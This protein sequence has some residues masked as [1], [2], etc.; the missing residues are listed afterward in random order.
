MTYELHPLCTLFP[1]LQ[2]LDFEALCQDILANGLRE[3]IVLHEGMILDGGN[4]YRACMHVGV[5]PEFREFGGGNIVDY[6]LSTN[7]YRRHLTPGQQAAIVSSAQNWAN[8]QPAHRPDKAGNVA[9]LSTVASRSA[10]SGASERTQ[11]MADKVAKADPGLAKKVA[12]GEVSLPK[13][14]KQVEAKNPPKPRKTTVATETASPVT[15]EQLAPGPVETKPA[16]DDALGD[17]DPYDEIKRMQAELDAAHALVKAAEADDL[18]AE[19]MKWRRAY[20]HAQREQSIAMD[21]YHNEAK[22]H[23]FKHRQLM[24]CGKAVGEEDPDKVAAAVEAFV[25][26]HKVAA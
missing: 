9:G 13:A 11:R 5:E 23:K 15:P 18:K 6:V 2:G 7:L 12:H 21:R 17:F 22:M 19:A 26:V 4:R 1:R 3:A 8:A 24:R 20:D 10:Q 16:E 14:V 25:R